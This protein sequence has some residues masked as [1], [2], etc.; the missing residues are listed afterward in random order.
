[1]GAEPIRRGGCLCGAVRY[2]YSGP[3]GG[4]LGA[5][6]I[7][8][9]ASC[10]RAQGYGA[11]AAPILASGWRVTAGEA[12]IR[13]HESSPGKLRAFC[14]LCGSP[15]YS[16]RPAQPDGLRLRLGSLDR[17]PPGLTVDAHI[18]TEGAPAWAVADDAPRY[19]GFEPGR[20]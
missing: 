5:V 1:M 9:C 10:R 17:A 20:G 18:F 8:H 15:L 14:S 12:V 4:D 2:R 16:R 19:A 11:A 3:I 7:C 13:E 6:T